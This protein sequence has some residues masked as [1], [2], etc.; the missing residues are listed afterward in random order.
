MN[1]KVPNEIVQRL[2]ITSKR[3]VLNGYCEICKKQK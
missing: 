3:L 2:N 1:I